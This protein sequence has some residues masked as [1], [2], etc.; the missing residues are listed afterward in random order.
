MKGT[1]FYA[2]PFFDIED[3]VNVT[4]C[5]RGKACRNEESG[6]LGAFVAGK[7]HADWPEAS[8]RVSLACTKS[9][10]NKQKARLG[11]LCRKTQAC[12]NEESGIW[13]AFVAGKKHADW[14]ETSFRGLLRR[15]TSL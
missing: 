9:M 13:G 6:I 11:G 1:A 10:Q 4:L 8:F 12:R 2:V 14:P 15:T 3:F 7:K 5:C